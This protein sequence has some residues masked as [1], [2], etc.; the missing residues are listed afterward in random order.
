[1]QVLC[2]DIGGTKFSAA[3]VENNEIIEKSTH[4]TNKSGGEKWM[5]E[6]LECI[7][8][9][10]QKKYIINYCG[11]GFGG[12][13]DY[14]KQKI[15]CSTLIDGWSNFDF[16]LFFKEKYDFNTIIDNDANLGALGEAKFGAGI[17]CNPLFYMTL[18]T[19]IGGGIIVDNKILHGAN[20]CSG[21][22]GHLTII[23]NGPLCPCGAKG[24]LERLCSGLSLEKDYG[25]KP[26]ELFRDREFVDKYVINLAKGLLHCIKLINPE[27]IVI[28]GGL[29]KSGDNLFIP[30]RKEL[31]R[32]TAGK[33]NS[34]IDVQPA[35]LG[36][37]N[38]LFG[39]YALI[40]E[41]YKI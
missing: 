24:C 32:Q 4:I 17:N 30:L 31:N 7:I 1:M 10:Y 33:I 29:S 12:P 37:N 35:K 3:I 28:G 20:S 19:G 27:R 23:Q 34:I 16:P 25:K 21:E 18:S 13:V 40:K 39:A 14:K 8:S 2:I 15:F 22:I 5:L 41:R 9:N 26:D 6:K 38:V 11:I 36:D